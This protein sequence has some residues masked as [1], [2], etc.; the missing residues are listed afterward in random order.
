MLTQAVFGPD[1]PKL[2][3]P[4]IF[5]MF[6]PSAVEYVVKGDESDEKLADL[7]KRGITPVKV[8]RLENQP[9]LVTT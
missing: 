1:E 3:T 2:Y 7:E 5:H 4:G 9:D 6:K 8:E